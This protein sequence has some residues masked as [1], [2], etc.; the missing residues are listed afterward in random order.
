MAKVT[1]RG[2][3]MCDWTRNWEQGECSQGG[4]RYLS[5]KEGSGKIVHFDLRAH[6]LA[7]GVILAYW[8]SSA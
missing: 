6:I 4:M 5:F 2:L 3:E 8:E 7:F 1:A